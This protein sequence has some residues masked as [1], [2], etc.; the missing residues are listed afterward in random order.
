MILL[1]GATGFIGDAILTRLDSHII[2]TLGRHPTKHEGA[3]YIYGEIDALSDYQTILENVSEVIHCAARTHIMHDEIDNSFNLY[4][5]V[6]VDGT[7][8]LARQAARAGVKRFIF[9]SSIKVNGERNEL[10]SPYFYND[11]PL[12]EDYYGISKAQAEAGL[13]AI[14]AET[15]MDVVIIRPPLVYGP[16]VKANFQALMKAM[17]KGL[18]L[19]LGAI[20]NSRSLVALDNLVDLIVTCIDHPKA[21]NQIFLVSDD[22]DV[23]TT[24]LLKKI[25]QAFGKKSRLIPIPMSWIRFAASILGKKAV[26]ER[27]CGSLQVDITH[28][29]ET[30]DWRPP[31]TMEQ[32]LAKIAAS[33]AQASQDK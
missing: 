11:N 14:A 25:A 28:T 7:L 9:L 27:L 22:Q 4:R 13:L 16:A 19:P 18:P 5:Q 32:Q 21:A 8:N 17:Y 15:G 24:E 29:K 33:I 3:Q 23:S 1:T 10:G 20:Y 26:A 6:N 31:V 2:R 30:L 12:P